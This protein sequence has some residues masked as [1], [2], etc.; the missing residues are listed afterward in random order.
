MSKGLGITLITL[1]SILVVT[2]IGAMVYVITN[3]KNLSFNVFSFGSNY[4]TKL[5]AESEFDVEDLDIDSSVGDVLI[6][7]NETDKVKVEIYSDHVKEYKLE[8]IDGK[9]IVKFEEKNRGFS[10]FGKSSV[11]KIY[12]PTE[13]DKAIKAVMN[14]GDLKITDLAKSDLDVVSK[15]GDV[16]VKAIK[17]ATIDSTTGDVK[18]TKVE[19]L[20]VKAKTGDIKVETLTNS[21][22]ADS[23]AG[24]V[25]IQEATILKNSYIK[26]NVGD[27][28]I[29][30]IND[31]VYVDAHSNV[32]DE[33]ISH[34]NRKAE[35]EL[36]ITCDVGDIKVS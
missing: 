13:Y 14:V 3:G 4:S 33:K 29:N 6:E 25:K 1:L 7:T 20:V 32:G 23:K 28:K 24:D 2:I 35:F 5:V 9:I 36:K 17:N 15:V 18:I 27:V 10:F 16:K 22:K 8:S 26:S 19:N 12:V 31:D 34:N 30:D 21:I 11:I